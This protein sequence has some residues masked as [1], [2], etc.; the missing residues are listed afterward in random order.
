MQGK[1]KKVDTC[2][3]MYLHGLP[4]LMG[5]IAAIFIVNGLSVFSQ[6]KG[7]GITII[8]AFLSGYLAGKMLLFL[9]RRI[10]P[11]MD[12]EEFLDVED[13]EVI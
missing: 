13:G 9:G 3:V 1:I 12:S 10:E 7:I 4:G 8:I 5:G 11:Y 6:L 2:G